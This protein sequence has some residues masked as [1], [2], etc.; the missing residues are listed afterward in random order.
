M[1]RIIL[2]IL[3][4]RFFIFCSLFSL[5]WWNFRL[6]SFRRFECRFCR[7]FLISI[8]LF[9][10]SFSFFRW[11]I[12]TCTKIFKLIRITDTFF[13]KL[14]STLLEVFKFL[15]ISWM[16]LFLS[17]GLF[18]F[19]ELFFELSVTIEFF[20]HSNNRNHK[21]VTL[22]WE[23]S[24]NFKIWKYKGTKFNHRFHVVYTNFRMSFLEKVIG[25][26]ILDKFDDHSE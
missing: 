20:N 22:L 2:L 8:G 19:N 4:L 26:E 15:F 11:N 9:I 6:L 23:M 13:V 3:G 18:I 5:L 24:F 1:N 10:L 14:F 25:L 16:S 12:L 21:L 7:F 17:L